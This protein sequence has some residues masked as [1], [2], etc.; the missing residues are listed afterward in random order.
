MT[1]GRSRLLPWRRSGRTSLATPRFRLGGG[2][3]RACPRRCPHRPRGQR[4]AVLGHMSTPTRRVTEPCPRHVPRAASGRFVTCLVHVTDHALPRARARPEHRLDRA[5]S[6]SRR[7][8]IAPSSCPRLLAPDVS[9]TTNAQVA[10]TIPTPSRHRLELPLESHSNGSS[11]T[12]TRTT[13]NSH[14]KDAGVESLLS[15]CIPFGLARVSRGALLHS[16]SAPC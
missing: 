10:T 14:R 6:P 16:A 12:T 9:P 7:T 3:I 13:M 1:S 2:S 11:H 8:S 15:V 4:A 5:Q